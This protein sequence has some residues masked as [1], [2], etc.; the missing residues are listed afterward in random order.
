MKSILFISILCFSICSAMA[1]DNLLNKL[2]S[3]SSSSKLS[4][5]QDPF[6]NEPVPL[7]GIGLNAGWGCAY[8]WG[9][10]YSYFTTKHFD[11]NAG[12]G[13]SISG[14]KFGAGTRFFFMKEGSSPFI[15]TNIVHS[16]GIKKLTVSVNE[17]EAIYFIPANQAI[18]F[19]TGYK[20]DGYNRSF[21]INLGYGLP[22]NGERVI[23]KEG[24]TSSAVKNFAEAI[25]L[26]GLEISATIIFKIGN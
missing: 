2:K 18:F 3:V 5:Y 12:I 19:R 14:I 25:A 26:G 21:L 13:L 1:N 24:S 9:I 23:Y 17:D 11:I 4:Y 22:F 10:E 20:I 7:H 6:I 8:G 16:N 15:G